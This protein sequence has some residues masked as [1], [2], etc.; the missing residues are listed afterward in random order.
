MKTDRL[1]WSSLS[2]WR[3]DLLTPSAAAPRN[4]SDLGDVY[5]ADP[6]LLVVCRSGN[7]RDGFASLHELGHRLLYGDR[8]WQYEI[9]PE[10]KDAR[11][12]EERG[13]PLRRRHPRRR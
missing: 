1:L 11:I 8:T 2:P 13:L 3:A 7:R 12:G 5:R 6:R 10:L 4:A 9:C